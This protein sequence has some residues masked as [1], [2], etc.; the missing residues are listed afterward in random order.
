MA[1][2]EFFKDATK[3]FSIYFKELALYFCGYMLGKH[4][5]FTPFYGMDG[6]GKVVLLGCS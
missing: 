5:V 1:K 6:F 4:F 2:L 3:C